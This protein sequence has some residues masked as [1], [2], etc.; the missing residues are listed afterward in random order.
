MLFFAKCS[1]ENF[2]TCH[3]KILARITAMPVI[4]YIL[5]IRKNITITL[6]AADTRVASKEG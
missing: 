4:A 2:N 1:C 6:C 5:R 3:F